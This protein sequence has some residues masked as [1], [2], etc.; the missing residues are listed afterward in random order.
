MGNIYT[1]GGIKFIH[2][3]EET[4]FLL[5]EMIWEQQREKLKQLHFHWLQEIASG[6]K[7]VTET[8][9]T[10]FLGYARNDG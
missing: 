5:W 8:R 10:G 3:Y 4:G 6:D 1:L 9:T 2:V 7:N